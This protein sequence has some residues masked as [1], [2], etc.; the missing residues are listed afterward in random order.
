MIVSLAPLLPC[1]GGALMWWRG[2]RWSRATLACWA[3]GWMAA[4]LA[5][6]VVAVG[7]GS[8]VRYRWAAGLDV[9]LVTGGAS[10]VVAVMVPG[11]AL[12][13]VAYA[14]FHEESTGLAR[15]LGVIVV[16]VGAM[17]A[18]VLADDLLMLIVAWE[19]VGACS[20]VLIGHRW[21]DADNARAAV[22]AFVATHVGD[23]G[24]FAAAGAAFAGAGS[25][26]YASLDRL[27]G[28][29][30]QVFV[31]GIVLAATAKSAQLPFSTWLF[32]AMAGPTSVSA[33]LHSAT[34][35]AAG[36]FILVR[37]QPALDTVGWFAPSVIVIGLL[38]AAAGGVVAVRQGHAKKI[39]AASTSAN[40]GLMF[41]AVGAGFPA[42]AL[43]HLVAHAVVKS[44]M[45]MS[46]GVAIEA[47]GTP[48]VTRMRLGRELPGATVA[49][50]VLAVALAGIPPLGAAWTKEAVVAAAGARGAW[51]AL[52]TAIAGA[53]GAAYALRFQLL[54]YGRRQAP[55]RA[56][57][58]RPSTVERAALAVSAAGCIALGLLWLPAAEGL[59]ERMTG[60]VLAPSSA[61]ETVVSVALLAVAAGLAL[62]AVHSSDRPG[63]VGAGESRMAN[64]FGIEPLIK[65]VVVDPFLRLSRWTIGVGEAGLD[66]PSRSVAR[67]L[68]RLAVSTARF[69]DRVVDAGPR[70][71]ARS[72]QWTAR[73]ATGGAESTVDGAVRE[74]SRS[75]GVAGRQLRRTQTGRLHQYYAVI[76]AAG[77]VLALAFGILS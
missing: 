48:D 61:W 53:F 23:L 55:P 69:D 13:V 32:A 30:A 52:S 8:S 63:R 16:F 10:S 45:F 28:W 24:L 37:L 71:V 3:V 5:V 68:P 40:Y 46:A 47:A 14:A 49:T 6:V 4:T 41:V 60:G 74:V 72:A 12:V 54:V 44:G 26:G 43:V 29:P 1:L 76:V 62:V 19:L 65:L 73:A 42:A 39:L 56:V 7:A 11:V 57:V 25:L 21:R 66:R 35:V 22:A 77:I 20:W 2:A 38:T 51:L 34:M 15:L 9:T 59:V 67:G 75:V 70:A 18:L 27:H 31:A 36:A 58:R 64:W 33:L 17:E 50:G